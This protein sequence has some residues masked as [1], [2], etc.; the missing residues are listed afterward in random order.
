MRPRLK[1]CQLPESVSPSG[2]IAR[3]NLHCKATHN[4]GQTRATALRQVP[5]CWRM[6]REGRRP[7]VG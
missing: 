6:A 7:E 4:G 5:A 2:E 1:R 3:A